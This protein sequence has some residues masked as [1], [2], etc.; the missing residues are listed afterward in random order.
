[1]YPYMHLLKE[2]AE[3]GI[4]AYASNPSTWESEAGGLP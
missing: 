2:N 1:M 3:L 4:M